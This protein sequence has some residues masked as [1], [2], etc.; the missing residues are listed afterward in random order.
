MDTDAPPPPTPTRRQ[1][2][3]EEEQCDE[4]KRPCL[5]T[6]E[7]SPLYLQRD[8]RGV[9]RQQQEAERQVDTYAQA[10]RSPPPAAAPTV[11]TEM[12][13]ATTTQAPRRRYPP[14]IVEHLPNW[15]THMRELKRSLGR[16]ANARPF[17]RGIRFSPKDDQ[18]FRLVQR[19]L[20]AL[21][22][23]EGSL[24]V[25][26]LPPGGAQLEGGH[27]WPAEQRD[28]GRGGAGA[29]RPGLRPRVCA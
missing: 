8:P 9:R 17:G 22:K 21:E 23:N 25:L 13:A 26:L 3:P 5:T 11:D 6:R 1:H 16:A 2:S 19:Y 12:T 18:E 24:L 7:R 20:T 29:P 15:A 14:L 4:R 27:P 28:A 10:A